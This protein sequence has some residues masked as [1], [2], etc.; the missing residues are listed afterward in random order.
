[1]ESLEEVNDVEEIE[2]IA[3]NRY[4]A[5]LL[6]AKWSRKLN[7]ERKAKE[8]L[9]EEEEVP[10]PPEPKVTSVALKDLVEGTIKF[11]RPSGQRKSPT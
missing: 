5:V 10:Q 2:K 9:S 3:D 1:M 7:A 6:A 4:E 11:E 8:E